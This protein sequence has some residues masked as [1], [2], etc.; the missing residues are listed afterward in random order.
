MT[1]KR[2]SLLG[3]V[4]A[5]LLFTG[6]ST[7][8]RL[9]LTDP[10]PTPTV[11]IGD[12]AKLLNDP[13]IRDRI[14]RQP[15]TP[16][17]DAADCW[18][19]AIYDCLPVNPDLAELTSDPA[20][21]QEAEARV[22]LVPVGNVRRDVVEAIVAFHRET[23]DIEVLVLPSLPIQPESVDF[24]RSQVPSDAVYDQIRAAYGVT[25]ETPSTFIAVLPID[26]GPDGK[27]SWWFGARYGRTLG[28]NHGVF[29]YFRMANIEPSG[30]SPLTD[31][32]V[33]QRA[34]KYFARYVALL[35]LDFPPGTDAEYLNYGTMGGISDLDSMGKLWPAGRHPCGGT[36][37]VVCLIP[38]SSFAD[39]R[40]EVD[41][42]AAIERVN[43]RLSVPVDIL[44]LPPASAFVPSEESWSAEFG[45]DLREA[46][47]VQGASPDAV[48]IGVTDDPFARSA[49]IQP[50]VERIWHEE[51]LAV[52]SGAG[53]GVPGTPEHR[54][55]LYRL[56]LRVIYQAHYGMPLSD[57]PGDI[58]FSGVTTPD[59]LD[60]TTT[61]AKPGS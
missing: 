59:Q 45:D 28:L 38:D 13:A 17:F 25:A 21:C 58:L 47:P 6:C 16:V 52:V 8:A 46:L 32:L 30:G 49:D 61:P 29:S 12:L 23:A 33:L 10:T 7:P 57:D 1:G 48:V 4:V 35:F 5:C 41:L 34:T 22:C 36:E 14:L 2:V 54:E 31:E 53:A 56:L 42:I 60:G 43:K 3:L 20:R 9:G 18:G 24:E 37:P 51:R 11:D 55:R 15:P 27:N 40:F 19:L 26:T 39:S 50:H 44:V